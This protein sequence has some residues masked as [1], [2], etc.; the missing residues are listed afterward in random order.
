MSY[1]GNIKNG[2]TSSNYFSPT[3][4]LK[5][6][7]GGK[8]YQNLSVN[9]EIGS[10]INDLVNS[11]NPNL[12]YSS[13]P[14]TLSYEK[15]GGNITEKYTLSIGGMQKSNLD[16]YSGSSLDSLMDYGVNSPSKGM[17]ENLIF[18]DDEEIRRMIEKQIKSYQQN[19]VSKEDSKILIF[20]PSEL[21]NKKTKFISNVNKILPYIK[22]VFELTTN[23]ELRSDVVIKLCS[24]EELKEIHSQFSDNWSEGIQGFCINRLNNPLVFVKRDELAKVMLTIGHELGHLQ[25][26]SLDELEEEAKA[27]AFSIE[28]MNKI[29]EN[30]VANLANVFV[31]ESPAEDGVHNVAFNFVLKLLERGKSA[32]EIFEDLISGGKISNYI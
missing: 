14:I 31:N 16:L 30:N 27:Y 23:E 7:S 3:M 10:G 22:R 19:S 2:S 28:W 9:D 11:M 29:K 4:I 5:S 21:V 12:L 17:Y 18:E 1:E 26:S 8:S 24:Q 13:M 32:F 15:I 20:N 25:T 6:I